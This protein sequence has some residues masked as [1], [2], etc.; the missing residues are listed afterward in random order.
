MNPSNPKS[1]SIVPKCLK[2]EDPETKIFLRNHDMIV[3]IENFMSKGTEIWN[4]MLLVGDVVELIENLVLSLKA[5]ENWKEAT[6]WHSQV[7]SLYDQS[8]KL[9]RLFALYP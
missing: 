4:V 6:F 8:G 5:S 1:S 2:S 3:A 7:L 9:Y